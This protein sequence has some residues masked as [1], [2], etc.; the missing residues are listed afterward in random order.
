MY[1]LLQIKKMPLHY[2]FPCGI[3][4]S[5]RQARDRP[6]PVAR[7][8]GTSGKKSSPRFRAVTLLVDSEVYFA[9]KHH[10]IGRQ[11]DASDL[12]SELL[13]GWVLEENDRL[14]ARTPRHH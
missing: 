6:K 1:N 9:T 11:I 7:L 8:I 13:R 4:P 10:L 14:R 12:V 5:M 3:F 2:D